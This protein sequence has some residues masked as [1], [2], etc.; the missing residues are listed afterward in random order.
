MNYYRFKQITR[1]LEAHIDVYSTRMNELAAG[2]TPDSVKFSPEY[3]AAKQ[4]FDTAFKSLRHL[5][6][7][8]EKKT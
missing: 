6:T 7:R 3:R 4:G 2:I 5:K 8:K 1:A